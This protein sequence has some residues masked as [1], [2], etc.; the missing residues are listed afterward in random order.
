MANDKGDTI[1]VEI[2]DDGTVKLTTGTV[3]A[4]NHRSADELLSFL[5]RELGGSVQ[6]EKRGR[7]HHHT[8]AHGKATHRH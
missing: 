7:G 3:G 2:L 4:A 1:E 8:H 6:R 5:A